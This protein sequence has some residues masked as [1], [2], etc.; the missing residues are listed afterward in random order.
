MQS[1]F[2][3]LTERYALLEQLGDPLPKLDEVVDW[4]GFRPTLRRIRSKQDRRKGGRPPFDVVLMFKVLLLQQLYNLS[5]DQT[6]YQIRDRY[7]FSRF[8][9]LD[10]E[11]RVP[12]AKTIWLY[13]EQL[14]N[15]GLLDEVFSG[16]LSQIEGAGYV[17]RCGQIVDAAIMETPRQRN[18]R[19]ENEQIKKGDIPEGW[20]DNK[21]R[22]KDTQARWAR[23]AGKTYFGYKNHI[24]VDV[25]H[26]VIRRYAVSD[27]ALNDRHLLEDVLDEDNSSR[28]LWAD[29]NY[30]SR[31]QEAS[32]KKQGYRSHIQRQGQAKQPLNERQKA[33]NHKRSKTRIRVEHIFAQQSWMGRTVRTIGLERAHFKIGMMNLAYNVKR[34]AWLVEHVNPRYRMQP[35]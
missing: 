28:A 25:K 29:A 11:G 8:L 27:A 10:P 24:N 21:R 32:L 3:D 23:K 18:P 2:F 31:D 15:R 20:S 1:S 16:L 7:S 13:R 9:D 6:E 4:E 12:D 30:R 22:Q 33:A 19:E 34:L 35:T 26:K 5:D 17:A 14:K